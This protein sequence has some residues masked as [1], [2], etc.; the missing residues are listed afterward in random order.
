MEVLFLSSG[1][2]VAWLEADDFEGQC[3]IAVKRTLGRKINVPRFRQR[4]FLEGDGDEICDDYIFPAAPVKVQLVLLRFCPP[5]IV[6]DENLSYAAKK[7]DKRALERLLLCPRNPNARNAEYI[8]P[9]CFAAN[10]GHVEI[11]QLLLEAEAN[12]NLP[13]GSI[14]RLTPL[15]MAAMAGCFDAVRVLVGGGAVKDLDDAAGFSPLLHAV[16][17]DFVEI[18][19]FLVESG[20]CTDEIASDSSELNL[21]A[22]RGGLEMV[23]FLIEIGCDINLADGSGYT[24]LHSAAASGYLEIVQ[25]MVESGVNCHLLTKDG[26][27]ALDCAAVFQFADIECY[28][29]SLDSDSPPSK[30]RRVSNADAVSKCREPRRTAFA[31]NVPPEPK[32]EGKSLVITHLDGSTF[33]LQVGDD[34]TVQDVYKGVSEEISLKP[35]QKLQLFSEHTMLDYSRPLL[36]QVHGLN[37]S[38][39]IRTFSLNE[40]ATSLWNAIHAEIKGTLNADAETTLHTAAIAS[41]HF[42]HNFNLS[43]AGVTLPSSSL[44]TLTFGQHSR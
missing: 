21:A 29:S 17:C 15:H 26:L 7:N 43:L 27:S 19:R 20:A 11:I 24:P 1:E 38:S 14:Q 37:I 13:S 5:D 3:A 22:Q 2:R 4:L 36:Q 33:K 6:E 18:A 9:L 35:G 34:T 23:R 39:I 44:Q 8:T 28:L 30:L 25:L 31:S 16:R 10:K 42:G 41:I 40:F 32:E 12:V